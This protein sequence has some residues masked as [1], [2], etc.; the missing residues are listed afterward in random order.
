MLVYLSVFRDSNVFS[1]LIGSLQH[2]SCVIQPTV[3][4]FSSE[5]LVDMILRCG[6]NRLN[7]FPAF[8]MNHFR[9]ARENPKLLSMLKNLDD[10]LYSGMPLP[11]EDERWA[12]KNG[13]RL[14]VSSYR[15]CTFLL[16]LNF[17]RDSESFR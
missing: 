15:F 8:L 1:V 14:R 11:M 12:L 10:V 3:L 16:A 6:L 2:G 9:S 5:E 7:Q 4:N 17:F 13:L